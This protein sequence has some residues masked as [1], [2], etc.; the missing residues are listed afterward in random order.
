VDTL[1]EGLDA[2]ESE[3]CAHPVLEVVNAYPGAASRR[4]PR[5]PVR[6]PVT[7]RRLLT[8]AFHAAQTAGL[9]PL[10]VMSWFILRIWW[11][12]RLTAETIWHG[13]VGTLLLPAADDG[14]PV[15]R[16]AIAGVP[17]WA[18]RVRVVPAIAL[19]LWTAAG[20]SV[21]AAHV[22]TLRVAAPTAAPP[23]VR[24]VPRPAA[25]PTLVTVIMESV[26][27]KE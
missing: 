12:V 26:P 11:L 27:A 24:T 19:M 6:R 18:R 3:I 22:L 4:A 23:P 5:A 21:G 20:I 8:S 13:V 17:A 7:L 10:V 2:F 9:F 1:G 15:I 14:L 25:A 16:V